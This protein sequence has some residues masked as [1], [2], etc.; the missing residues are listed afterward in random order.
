MLNHIFVLKN[1]RNP[2]VLLLWIPFA[3]HSKIPTMSFKKK[4]KNPTQH[5]TLEALYAHLT[6]YYV[7]SSSLLFSVAIQRRA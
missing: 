1:E 2:G 3:E 5:K 6:F 4:Q 7:I